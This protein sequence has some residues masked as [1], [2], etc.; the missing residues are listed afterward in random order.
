MPSKARNRMNVCI[1]SV[2]A[3]ITGLLKKLCYEERDTLKVNTFV[4]CN[5]SNSNSNG[6]SNNSMYT[7]ASVLN[8]FEL[9]N[10]TVYVVFHFLSGLL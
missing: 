2:F 6:T 5:I 4:A 9:T 1:N 8:P 10:V 3:F 7:C